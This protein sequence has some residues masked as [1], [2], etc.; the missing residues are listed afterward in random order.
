M[1]RVVTSLTLL[2]GT[3]VPATDHLQPYV[4]YGV[5]LVD[6]AS[7]TVKWDGM[8]DSLSPVS[9]QLGGV[10]G[11]RILKVEWKNAGF[12][13]DIA[14]DNKSVDFVNL[15]IWLYEESNDIEL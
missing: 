6:R 7:D 3:L 5:N 8:T 4:Q 1:D 9:Y 12:H 15:Q 10:P 11:S 13:M 2:D 14:A